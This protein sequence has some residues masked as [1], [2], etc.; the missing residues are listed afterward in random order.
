MLILYIVPMNKL[1]KN[2]FLIKERF[3]EN[4]YVFCAKD[5]YPYNF[6]KSFKTTDKKSGIKIAK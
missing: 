1:V 3:F 6:R 5:G 4:K 2:I